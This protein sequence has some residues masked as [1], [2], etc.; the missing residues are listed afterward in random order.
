METSVMEDIY[1][2]I[3]NIVSEMIPEEW[4]KVYLYA[5][6]S[7]GVQSFYFHYY[8]QGQKNTVYSPDIVDIFDVDEDSM[9]MLTLDLCNCCK[10]LWE[11]FKNSKQDLWTNLTF[12]L[13]STG[14][15]KIDYDYTELSE[16]DDY[17]RQIIW[18]Y[19]NLRIEPPADRKRD[20]KILQD[21]L[22]SL[23]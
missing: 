13:E 12:I 16:I 17:E 5:Q 7:E 22:R 2:K 3:A 18:E 11:E 15:F 9:D 23:K 10:E 19:N 4:D 14:E 1:G 21:Y 8:P 6:V 20:V